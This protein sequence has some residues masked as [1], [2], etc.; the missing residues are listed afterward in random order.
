MGEA[1]SRAVE[2]GFTHVAFGD[3]FLEDVRAATARIGSPA[4]GLA[5]LFPLFGADTTALAREMVAADYGRE[6]PA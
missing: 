3:L 6:S 2:D 1:V 4:P 5:P